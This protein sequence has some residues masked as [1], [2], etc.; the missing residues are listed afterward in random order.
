M[1]SEM[2]PENIEHISVHLTA[3]GYLNSM[4]YLITRHA[5]AL[6]WLKQNVRGPFCAIAHIDEIKNISH[7]DEVYGTLPVHLIAA[8]CVRGA[9]F[10]F[11]N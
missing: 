5:G 10:S 8:V 6:Q 11:E 1:V 2:T 9:L 4:R 7:G 3:Q